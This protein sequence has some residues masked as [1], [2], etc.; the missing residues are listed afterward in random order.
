VQNHPI[1]MK[2]GIYSQLG[3]KN[4]FLFFYDKLNQY[5]HPFFQA[6]NIFSITEGTL[7][8]KDIKFIALLWDIAPLPKENLYIER[9]N[10]KYNLFKFYEK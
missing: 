1:L 10:V 4:G 6:K 8:P 9:D 3:L 7:E 5:A 2:N